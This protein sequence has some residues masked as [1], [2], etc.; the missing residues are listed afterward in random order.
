MMEQPEEKGDKYLY[1]VFPIRPFY[2]ANPNGE[3]NTSYQPSANYLYSIMQLSRKDLIAKNAKVYY[4]AFSKSSF[5]DNVVK[6]SHANH[7][8]LIGID[9][10]FEI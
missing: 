9:D 5:S 7:V 4:Y 3:Y 6:K 1:Q 2:V 8:T 10:L